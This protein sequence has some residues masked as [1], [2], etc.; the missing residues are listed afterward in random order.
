MAVVMPF[1]GYGV[2]RLL[3]RSSALTST[4]RA[5]A[6]GLGGYVGINAAALMAA[7]EFG[8]QPELFNRADGT[9]LYAPFDLAQTIPAMAF[10]HIT[11]AG[12]VEL[13]LTFGIVGYLQRANLPV[14][15]INHRDVPVEDAG[16]ERSGLRWRWA[17]VGIGTMIVLSPLGLL[18]PGGAFGEDAPADL[19]L[20]RYGLTAVPSGLNQYADFW[21]HTLLGGYG[22]SEGSNQTLGYLLS[23]LVGIAVI[24]VVILATFWLARSTQSRLEA[25]PAADDLG[26]RA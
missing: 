19:D 10:A 11:V 17:F 4:R 9:P 1:V 15:R 3:A 2:Y 13:A 16:A 7:T 25:E 6:A 18:A 20:G 26:A 5:L 14:M 21:S 12:F 22:F 8:L 24:A 23:A